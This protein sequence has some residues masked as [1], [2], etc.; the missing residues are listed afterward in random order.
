MREPTIKQRRLNLLYDDWYKEVI[1]RR[2]D[3][4]TL[5]Q[6]AAEFGVS[7]TCLANWL[8]EAESGIRRT[9]ASGRRQAQ[10]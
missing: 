8:R 1:R 7:P 5:G 9:T 2:A 3:G 4:L 10:E 6:I